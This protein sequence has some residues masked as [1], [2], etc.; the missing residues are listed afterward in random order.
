MLMR[1][2]SYNEVVSHEHRSHEYPSFI[3]SLGE[4]E[5]SNSSVQT[6]AERGVL[7]SP[8]FLLP[9]SSYTWLF[10]LPNKHNDFEH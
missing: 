2:A 4:P 1:C 8:A 9:V 7:I 5:I 3:K 10:P 6:Q